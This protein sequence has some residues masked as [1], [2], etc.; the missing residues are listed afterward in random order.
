[1]FTAPPTT[2][3]EWLWGPITAIDDDL[4]PESPNGYNRPLT[5]G[6]ER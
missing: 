5:N 4:P 3:D 1:M 2:I 6:Y